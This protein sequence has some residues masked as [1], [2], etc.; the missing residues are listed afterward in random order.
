MRDNAVVVSVKESLAWVQV[1]PQVSCTEC[2]ARSLCAGHKDGAGRLAVQN[3]LQARPGDEVE[4]EVPEANYQKD[5]M[6]IFGLLLV[7]SLAGLGLG[8]AA[9]PLS[10]LDPASNGLLG[11]LA[12]IL[13]AA[14]GL[15]RYYRAHRRKAG[16]PVIVEIL[17]RGGS[18]GET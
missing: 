9:R 3:P 11:L 2:S 16:Y 17:N 15:V 14:T 8:Y 5:M 12:G 18:H 7:A 4:I 1:T 13:I 10:S 6:R